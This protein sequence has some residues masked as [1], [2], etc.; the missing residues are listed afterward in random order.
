[1]DYED[2]KVDQN[3]GFIVW[4]NCPNQR[5]LNFSGLYLG[6]LY[7]GNFPRREC[8]TSIIGAA[9]ATQAE[10]LTALGEIER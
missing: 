2:L 8:E 5:V 4:R 1:M 7:M 6:A 10:E 3:F 9:L